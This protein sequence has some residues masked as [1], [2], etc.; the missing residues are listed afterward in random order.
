MLQGVAIL[1]VLSTEAVFSFL[2]VVDD[3]PKTAE[4]ISKIIFLAEDGKIKDPTKAETLAEAAARQNLDVL[5][6]NE[7][8]EIRRIISGKE[9][10]SSYFDGKIDFHYRLCP[11][12]AWG[13]S[14]NIGSGKCIV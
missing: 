14:R 3:D 11:V 5:R 13:F 10:I 2:I 1:I 4:I 8:V 12:G 7:T 9:T 6:D